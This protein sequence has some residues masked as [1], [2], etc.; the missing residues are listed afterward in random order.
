MMGLRVGSRFTKRGR[1]FL[2]IVPLCSH[3]RRESPRGLCSIRQAE[4]CYHS[5]FD[6]WHENPRDRTGGYSVQRHSLCRPVS[7][8]WSGHVL[9]SWKFRQENKLHTSSIRTEAFLKFMRNMYFSLFFP[10][11]DVIFRQ[12]SKYGPYVGVTGTT[13]HA[14][15]FN[16]REV[17]WNLRAYFCGSSM[18]QSSF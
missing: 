12:I 4:H 17:A 6:W 5:N 8:T 10:H 11:S 3:Q 13:T 1:I 14:M 9:R 18:Q 15:H 16:T 7:P 2:C